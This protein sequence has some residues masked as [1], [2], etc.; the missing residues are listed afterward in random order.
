MISSL[1]QEN[2]DI[3]S[4][5]PLGVK[6]QPPSPNYEDGVDVGYT[7]PAKWWN[8]LWNV[9][10]TFFTDCKADR[11][12][13]LGELLSLL[14]AVSITPSATDNHQLTKAANAVCR[15]TV[16]AYDNETVTEIIDGVSVTHKVN[17]P[18]VVG[19]TLYVPDTELL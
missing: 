19:F 10:T 16:E 14:S 4:S 17:Q 13:I 18:Y 2:I 9:I 6:E 7:A 8:W 3:F 15:N 5:D 11:Q 1:T 12:H